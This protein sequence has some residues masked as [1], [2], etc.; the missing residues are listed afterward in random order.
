MDYPLYWAVFADNIFEGL[1]RSLSAAKKMVNE[2]NQYPVN[3]RQRPVIEAC[4]ENSEFNN[5]I[6]YACR[7]DAIRAIEFHHFGRRG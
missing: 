6:A 4:D 3:W 7:S 5:Y 1:F 2:L